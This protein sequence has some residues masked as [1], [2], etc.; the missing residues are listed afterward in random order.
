MRGRKVIVFLN[1]IIIVSI[2]F[3]KI[4]PKSW[5]CILYDILRFFPTYIGVLLRLLVV[6]SLCNTGNNIYIAANVTIKNFQSLRIGDNFSI[7]ENSYIDAKGGVVIG[8]NVSIAHNS[9]L[10]G[11]NHT[12][13]NS[14]KPIKYNDLDFPGVKIG[15][16]VWIGC[17]VRVLAGT[18]ISN[19]TV[20]A[21][22]SVVHKAYPSNVLVAGVPG[23]VKKEI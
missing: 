18:I 10:V 6:R 17:G 2:F 19:R 11:F 13:D 4:F 12:W 9:S 8:D 5:R 20:I 15:S 14:L 22:G 7:H 3:L 1:P 16:D 21:A 23:K